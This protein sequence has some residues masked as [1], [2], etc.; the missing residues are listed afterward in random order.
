MPW[1]R[2]PGHDGRTPHYSRRRSGRTSWTRTAR[3]HREGPVDTERGVRRDYVVFPSRDSA[4]LGT[5]DEPHVSSPSTSR[6]SFRTSTVYILPDSDEAP[7]VR[8]MNLDFP[9][10]ILNPWGSDPDTSRDP[11]DVVRPSV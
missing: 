7:Y 3:W 2:D 4:G 6:S 11:G 1:T 10:R 5:S 9:R 8:R